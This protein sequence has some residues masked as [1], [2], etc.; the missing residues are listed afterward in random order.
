[1]PMVPRRVQD[2]R[3]FREGVAEWYE[4]DDDDDDRVEVLFDDNPVPEWTR[5]FLLEVID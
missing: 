4:G 2:K 5:K 1:M 3:T